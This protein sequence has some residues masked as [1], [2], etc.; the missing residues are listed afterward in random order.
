MSKTV[1]ISG[2]SQG[3]GF[4][5][6]QKMLAEGYSVIGS[7]RSGKIEGIDNPNFHS[8]ALDLTEESSIQKAKEVIFRLC[9]NNIDMLINNA[10]I[11][12]DLNS[13]APERAT[14]DKTFAVNVTGTVFFT[15]AILPKIKKNGKIINV[16]S[17]MGAMAVCST[18][19]SAAYR[20]SKSALNMYTKILSNRLQGRIN[21]AIMHPGWVKTNISPGSKL[22]APLTPKQ[23][24]ENMYRFFSQD[25]ETGTYW[26]SATDSQLPW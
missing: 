5:L 26:D 13:S 24:A 10:G 22:H 18:A 21:V 19:D 9:T 12:P 7:S 4:A 2:A 25:F 3:I 8:I 15:E 17:K 16:S 20:M 23:S 11:G 14:F 1:V 6:A